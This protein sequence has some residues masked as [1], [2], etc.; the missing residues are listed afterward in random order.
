MFFGKLMGDDLAESH[1]LEILHPQQHVLTTQGGDV[2][3][4]GLYHVLLVNHRVPLYHTT[5]LR[6]IHSSMFWPHRVEMSLCVAFTMS[7][8]SITEYCCTTQ[9]LYVSFTAACFDHTGWRCHSV[10]PVPCP[11]RQSPSTAVPHNVLFTALPSL[12]IVHNSATLL[13]ISNLWNLICPVL[14]SEW[15]DRKEWKWKEHNVLIWRQCGGYVICWVEPYR[16]ATSWWQHQPQ[17]CTALR[18]YILM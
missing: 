1:Q 16:S 6:I 4:C 2:T 9:H 18:S 14:I 11:L 15:S 10:W 7:S 3:L 8:S 17:V 12:Y 5:S 13:W